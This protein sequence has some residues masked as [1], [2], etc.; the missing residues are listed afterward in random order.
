MRSGKP[1]GRLRYVWRDL[2]LGTQTKG[3]TP[4]LD[5]GVEPFTFEGESDDLASQGHLAQ[6]AG[7]GT[8]GFLDLRALL[9]FD[10]FS[11][12]GHLRAGA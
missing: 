9:G 2:V 4:R 6:A 11:R 1:A 5:F 7:E 12:A 10:D 8:I 3:R